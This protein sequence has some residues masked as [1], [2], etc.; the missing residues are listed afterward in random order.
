MLTCSCTLAGT[1]ACRS[2]PNYIAV[3]GPPDQW[4][5]ISSVYVEPRKRTKTITE[6]YE[7][8]ELVKRTIE[9]RDGELIETQ[10]DPTWVRA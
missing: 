3:F 5:Y 7:A 6:I 2:C 8:G 1:Q 10:I 9:Y 4:R